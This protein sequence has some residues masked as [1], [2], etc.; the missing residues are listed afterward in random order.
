MSPYQFE[1]GQIVRPKVIREGW[2][3]TKDEARAQI[4]ARWIVEPTNE[5]VYQ[6][7]LPNGKVVPLFQME[8]E[9][10]GEQ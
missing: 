2:L 1:I 10:V 3:T 7:R 6:V 5:V 9:A 8:L 4:V